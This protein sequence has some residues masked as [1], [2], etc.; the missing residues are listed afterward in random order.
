[1]NAKL[2]HHI[3]MNASTNGTTRISD[4]SV[5]GLVKSTRPNRN[6]PAIAEIIPARFI[7]LIIPLFK[8]CHKGRTLVARE[9]WV[10]IRSIVN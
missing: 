3:I 2:M 9:L 5:V 7:Y 8:K 6:A 1:M 4:G 10:Q